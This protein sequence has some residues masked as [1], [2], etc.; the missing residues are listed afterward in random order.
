MSVVG[1]IQKYRPETERFSTYVDRMKLYFDANYVVDDKPVAVFLT[2]IGAKNYALLSDHYAPNKPR[3]QTLDD[4]IAV[5]RSHF[6][7][8]PIVIA[9]RFNF[10]KRYQKSGEF[11]PDFVADLRRLA[12]NCKFGTHLN[13]ALRD[14]FVCGGHSESVQKKLLLEKNLT[15]ATAVELAISLQSAEATTR[16][17]HSGK[18]AADTVDKLHKP[19]NGS[20]QPQS[21]CPRC[22]RKGHTSAQ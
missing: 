22:G 9:E 11:I 2:I 6:E 4:L 15:I 20:G 5:L 12:A 21:P 3:D 7:P 10:Y 17:M 13:D 14:R 8:E 16:A 19:G 18:A 1:K